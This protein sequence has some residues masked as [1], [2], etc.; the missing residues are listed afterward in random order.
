MRVLVISASALLLAGC[1]EAPS[2]E[3]GD[4]SYTSTVEGRA[5]IA[6]EA[7]TDGMTNP[8]RNAYRTANDY[9]A[10]SGFSR[11]G[12]IDQLSSDAGEGYE[13]AD[14]TVAVDALDADWNEQ[15]A[16]SARSYLEMSGFPCKGL[17]DPLSSSAGEKF[18]RSEA[19][20]GA[21]QAGAC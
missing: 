18:S 3:F 10:M 13:L 9:I 17:I 11:E 15:A 16:R 4:A 14:A 7:A 21:Q 20:Y 1:G 12:L 2:K 6:A 19:E 5:A 8:Q